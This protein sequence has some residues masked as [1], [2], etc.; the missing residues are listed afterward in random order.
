MLVIREKIDPKDGMVVMVRG[1]S[2][3]GDAAFDSYL[4]RHQD[5]TQ[6]HTLTLVLKI[7]LNSNSHKASVGL[8][9]DADLNPFV[10]EKWPPGK[11]ESFKKVFLDDAARWNNQFWL[12]PPAGYSG[13]DVKV[14]NRTF[15]PNIYCHLY[16]DA[17][18]AAN[19]AHCSVEVV[20][21]QKSYTNALSKVTKRAP[22]GGT[23][24]SHAGLLD[25]LDIIPYKVHG[26]CRTIT[27]EIGHHLG[28][29]HIGKESPGCAVA[30]LLA[31]GN[32]PVGGILSGGSNATAC[33]TG[34]DAGS[35]T[36][37]MGGGSDFAPANAKPWIDRIAIHTQTRPQD[38]RVVLKKKA[39]QLVA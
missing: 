2:Q 26:K 20:Y 19:A 31:A 12:I 6:N 34:T 14:G 36:N 23:F 22:D 27:H 30:I 9:P 10:V 29:P 8:Q 28:L 13:L 15:R 7:H 37:V 18:S 39:P 32:V 11:F 25:S 33:Y 5:G 3:G 1:T 17:D 35:A 4:K 24:R 21:L 38:W 16:V